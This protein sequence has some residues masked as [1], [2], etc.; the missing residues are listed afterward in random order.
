MKPDLPL[1]SRKGRDDHV[2]PDC[3]PEEQPIA[4]IMLMAIGGMIAFFAFF[5][6][7]VGAI[8]VDGFLAPSAI[9]FVIAILM[10]VAGYMMNKKHSI[11]KHEIMHMKLEKAKCSYC[12]TQNEPDARKCDSC[13]APLKD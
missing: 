12:G 7:L 1:M 8:A 2:C 10:I 11:M 4:P 3:A 9:A 6:G 5:L 13:G